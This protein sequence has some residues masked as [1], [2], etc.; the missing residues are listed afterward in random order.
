MEYLQHRG[1][2][3]IAERYRI[4][5]GEIDLVFLEGGTVVFVE[6]KG[7]S[8]DAWK[9]PEEMVTGQKRHKLFRAARHFLHTR[10]ML[11]YCCRFDV[12]SVLWPPDD[13]PP[14]ITHFPDA[15]TERE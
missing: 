8:S 5:G 14:K 2:R 4:A 6:V 13:R 10:S 12:V 11:D 3:L 1:F 15:F 7:L 9:E